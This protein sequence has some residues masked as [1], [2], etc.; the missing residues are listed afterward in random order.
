MGAAKRRPFYLKKLPIWGFTVAMIFMTIGCNSR[1]TTV[2]EEHIVIEY[3]ILENNQHPQGI[4][5]HESSRAFRRD[6]HR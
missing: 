2:E 1:K 6:Y 5:M 3:N 4:T